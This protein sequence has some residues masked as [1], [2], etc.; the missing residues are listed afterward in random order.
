MI[1]NKNVRVVV[2]DAVIGKKPES[3]TREY[4]TGY[5]EFQFPFTVSFCD[6]GEYKVTIKGKKA[7]VKRIA[8]DE[9]EVLL[10][11]EENYD[12]RIKRK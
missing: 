5:R 9:N 2:E 12:S 8:S 1:E 4:M 6:E 7:I 10:E 3:V 11:L